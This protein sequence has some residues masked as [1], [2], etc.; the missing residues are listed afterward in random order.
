MKKITLIALSLLL[1]LT[2]SSLM[3]SEAGREDR[4]EAK[5]YRL[6]EEA[7]SSHSSVMTSAVTATQYSDFLNQFAAG[8]DP[9]HLYNEAMGSDP[10]TASI[11]RV[12]EPGRWHYEVIAGRENCPICYVSHLAQANYADRL[13]FSSSSPSSTSTFNFN[14]QIEDVTCNNDTFEVEVPSTMLTLVSSSFP[15][16]TSTSNFDSYI[17]DVSSAA[18]LL[19]LL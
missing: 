18:A 8:S 11:V 10:T 9:N 16:S 14:S 17:T 12:G 1:S 7:T 2:S 5:D 15:T 6:Q 4:L 19:G 3:A 13:Q